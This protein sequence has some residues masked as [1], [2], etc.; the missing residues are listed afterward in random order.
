MLVKSS[1]NSKKKRLFE[2]LITLYKV[3]K[4]DHEFHFSTNPIL[5]KSEITK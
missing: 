4:I 3:K 1:T 5:K 2:I